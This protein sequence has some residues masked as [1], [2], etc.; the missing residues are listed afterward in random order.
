MKQT[1]AEAP[2][3]IPENQK[4]KI[5]H[6]EFKAEEVFFMASDG[7]P[8]Q[9]QTPGENVSLSLNFS[10]ETEQETVFNRLA[11]GGNITMPLEKTFWGSR[12][13]RVVDKFGINW[14]LNCN[15]EPK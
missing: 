4:S 14:M 5:M 6:A 1:F 15:I 13:G 11:D 9:P 8:G 3:D 12:F 10:D 2:M 7:M